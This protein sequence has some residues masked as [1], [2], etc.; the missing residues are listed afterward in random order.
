MESLDLRL[1]EHGEL[2]LVLVVRLSKRNW[3]CRVKRTLLGWRGPE[4]D[5]PIGSYSKIKLAFA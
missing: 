4:D 5:L 1:G 2:A 3:K